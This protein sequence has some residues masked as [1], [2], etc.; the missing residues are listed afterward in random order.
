VEK[1]QI[2]PQK[3]HHIHTAYSVRFDA[4]LTA[5]KEGKFVASFCMALK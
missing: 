2:L 4:R 5:P 3:R 1:R